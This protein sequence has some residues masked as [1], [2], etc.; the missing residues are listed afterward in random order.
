MPNFE[1]FTDK[2]E[3][4]NKQFGHGCGSRAGAAEAAADFMLHFLR[5]PS[6]L[7]RFRFRTKEEIDADLERAA[8]RKV[9][10]TIVGAR[11]AC[12]DLPIQAA[13]DRQRSDLAGLEVAHA[14]AV[15]AEHHPSED[16]QTSASTAK[17]AQDIQY[18]L[19]MA[20]E[21]RKRIEEERSTKAGADY[22]HVC[23]GGPTGLQFVDTD[24]VFLR[25]WRSSNAS[26]SSH[27]L[28]LHLCPPSTSAS[29]FLTYCL[30]ISCVNHWLCILTLL[31]R[32][33]Q[34]VGRSSPIGAAAA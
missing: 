23:I 9:L 10:F 22:K 1:T 29:S 20:A 26:E 30:T 34:A 14:K 32:L 2:L 8:E 15:A 19:D 17:T 28:G 25:S 4:E 3:A 21:R 5:M 12:I 24:G 18:D 11:L 6:L 27:P 33:Q 7:P 13:I 16:Q 31:S